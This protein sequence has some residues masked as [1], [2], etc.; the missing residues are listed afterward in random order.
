MSVPFTQPYDMSSSSSSSSPPDKFIWTVH[1]G[2]YSNDS[3]LIGAFASEAGAWWCFSRTLCHAL[4]Q[5]FFASFKEANAKLPDT[6]KQMKKG[7]ARPVPAQ[8]GQRVVLGVDE[9]PFFVRD[10]VRY[11]REKLITL[12]R[13][14]REMGDYKLNI[15]RVLLQS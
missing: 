4:E 10:E 14:V 8:P 12:A 11:Y 13:Q 6:F 9:Q 1:L 7:S 5:E 15:V 2:E 3:S